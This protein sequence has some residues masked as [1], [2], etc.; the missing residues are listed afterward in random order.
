MS[1]KKPRIL[2]YDEIELV[3]AL[4]EKNP[5]SPEDFDG[6]SV[7]LQLLKTLDA[8]T[9][10]R[11]HWMDMAQKHRAE[12]KEYIKGEGS[13]TLKKALKERDHFEDLSLEFDDWQAALDKKEE[14]L[15]QKEKDTF[16]REKEVLKRELEAENAILKAKQREKDLSKIL[17]Q[18]KTMLEEIRKQKGKKNV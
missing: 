2:S 1:K 10:Q 7:S 18:R 9:K 16:K 12:R 4:L 15:V 8:R 11:K 3:R 13:R 6:A 14:L 17:E 5:S